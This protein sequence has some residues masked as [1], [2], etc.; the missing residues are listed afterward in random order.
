VLL[1]RIIDTRKFIV[2]KTDIYNITLNH[3]FIFL[4]IYILFTI[5]NQNVLQISELIV[6]G[7]V[8]IINYKIF[9]PLLRIKRK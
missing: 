2:I 9:K 8:L 5:E 3:L 6:L 4:M 7:F 1:I